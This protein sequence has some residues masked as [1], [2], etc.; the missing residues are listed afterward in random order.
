MEK[1][2]EIGIFY[3]SGTGNTKAIAQLYTK[4]FRKLEISTDLIAIEKIMQ[5]NKFESLKEYDLY[6][7]GFPVH[8]FS[9]PHIFFKFLDRMPSISG[10]HAFLFKSLGDP[11]CYGGDT[12]KIRKKLI[13]KGYN[14]FHE[15]MLVMPANVA[16]PYPDE[17]VKQLYE[18][19]K[20]KIAIFVHQI[21]NLKERLQPN[22]GYLK[23]ISSLFSWMESFGGQYFGKYL[24][25]TEECNSCEI[26]ER[27]C[28]TNN[29]S[30]I[31]GKP[32]FGSECTFCMRCIYRCPQHAIKN[33]YMGFFIIRKGYNLKNTLKNENLT[34]NYINS[35]TRG[36]F[37]HFYNYL[38]NQLY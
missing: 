22:P 20:R 18:T 31:D 26:C 9:A 28:P 7:F 24:Y 23:L 10:K 6:G 21:L 19:A 30:I 13:N 36:Y 1:F 25:S 33:K 15:D 3:F 4:E 5:E 12:S 16:I 27:I 34:G 8:A 29:I 37:K 14:I 11:I 2:E 32:Q 35:E 17:L 38:T